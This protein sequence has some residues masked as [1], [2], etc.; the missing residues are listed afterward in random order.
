M[1]RKP[2]FLELRSENADAAFEKTIESEK[3]TLRTLPSFQGEYKAQ[4]VSKRLPSQRHT[5]PRVLDVG[6]LANLLATPIKCTLPLAD[7]LKVK[8][9]LW[10]DGGKCF[11]NMGID[12]S[13]MESET[14][15]TNQK[16]HRS[17]PVPLNKVG[18]YCEGKDGNTTL[19]AEFN[20]CKYIAILN[21][22]AGIA[23]AT[24]S[25][26]EIWG[27]LALPD[28]NEIEVSRWLHRKIIRIA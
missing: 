15:Q 7:V 20:E 12:I 10:K 16:H 8:P 6:N 24:K 22:G 11:N 5:P 18:E 26:L 3:G 25:T 17:K 19:L 9:K 1:I 28:S 4:S 14:L 23:I 27:K 2:S 13:L 21:S